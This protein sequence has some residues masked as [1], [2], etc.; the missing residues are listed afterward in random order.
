MSV[1]RLLFLIVGMM[2]GHVGG[3]SSSDGFKASGARLSNKPFHG[4]LVCAALVVRMR[5]LM[6]QYTPCIVQERL[7]E[8]RPDVLRFFP[9]A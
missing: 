5:D 3:G 6:S 2:K 4:S 8:V 1:E 9:V 7:L